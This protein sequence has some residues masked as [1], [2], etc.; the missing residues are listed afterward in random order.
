[1]LLAT[2]FLLFQS[3][4][5]TPPPAKKEAVKVNVEDRLKLREAQ[6]KLLESLVQQLQSQLQAV[7]SLRQRDEASKAARDSLETTIKG[8][9]GKQGCTLNL[10]TLEC[11]K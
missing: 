4:A 5:A 9:E 10:E 8:I 6:V 7:T 3:G 11:T 2:P 1:M